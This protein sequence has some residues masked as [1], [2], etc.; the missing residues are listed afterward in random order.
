MGKL[1]KK[2]KKVTAK[3]FSGFVPEDQIDFHQFGL[4][5]SFDIEKYL[6][7]FLEDCYISKMSKVLVITG[8]GSVVRP[9]VQKLLKTNKHVHSFKSAGYFNGQSGAFEVELK[10]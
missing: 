3:V 5:T 4:L 1:K 2:S 10:N 8:K 9:A 7:E 6:C